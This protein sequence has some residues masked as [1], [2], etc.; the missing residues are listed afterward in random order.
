MNYLTGTPF[1]TQL[2]IFILI[3]YHCPPTIM[4]VRIAI[5]VKEA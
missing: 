1:Q 4:H 5:A 2:C 3:T